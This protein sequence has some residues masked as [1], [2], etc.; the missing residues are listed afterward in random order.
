MVEFAELIVDQ[1]AH[2]LQIVAESLQL[3]ERHQFDKLTLEFPVWLALLVSF[4]VLRLDFLQVAAV[5]VVSL[6]ID[7]VVR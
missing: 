2:C 4:Y 7:R 3:H 5:G 1:R 6:V